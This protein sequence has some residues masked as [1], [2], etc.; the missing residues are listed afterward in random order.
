MELQGRVKELEEQ[1]LG[2]AAITYDAPEILARFAS[3]HGIT[4]PLLSDRG[5]AVIKRYG[6]LNT[7]VQPGSRAYGIPFPGT[8]LLDRTGRVVAR[9]FE[10]AYQERNTVASILV[11]QGTGS[12]S[13]PSVSAAT[14]HLEVHA[15]LADGVVSPG[16]RTSLVLEIAP[17]PG[18]HVYAP[19]QHAYQV[20]RMVFDPQPWLEVHPLR[21]PASEIYHFVPLDER[22]EVYQKPF[23]LIQDLTIRATPDAQKLLASV[24]QVT[25]T[26]RLEYQACDDKFCFA[27]TSVPLSWT[28]DVRPLL[29]PQ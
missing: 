15:R 27:P 5:S 25:L 18:I 28:V 9:Y 19:G 13:G 8:F 29:R 22:V 12:G 20:V 21:Y 24:R 16:S 7:T 26:G 11:R 10:Q 2:L 6:L 14:A 23:R 1:G 4:F 3:E 17:R